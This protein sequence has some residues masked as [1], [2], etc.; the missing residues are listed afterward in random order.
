MKKKL[1]QYDV[2]DFERYKGKTIWKPKARKRITNNSILDIVTQYN[3]EIQGL[4]NYY[5]IASNSCNLYNFYHIMEYSMYKTLSQK[6]NSTVS[7]VISQYKKDKNFAV[8]YIDKNGKTKYR[9]FYNKGF[10]QRGTSKFY[11][12]KRAVLY[13]CWRKRT[14]INKATSILPMWAM[15]CQRGSFY[16]SGTKS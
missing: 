2:L 8:P 10:Y 15:R 14:N 4:Y 5:S 11:C 16:A 6:L 3:A 13:Q 12:R 1:Q 9:I 7:K